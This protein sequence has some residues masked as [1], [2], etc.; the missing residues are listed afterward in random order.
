MQLPNEEIDISIECHRCGEPQKRGYN[1]CN[2]CGA[3]NINAFRRELKKDSN[4]SRNLTNLARYTFVIL[5]LIVVSIFTGDDL[6]SLIFWT[7]C[8]AIVDVIF[9]ILQPEVWSLFSIKNI[10]IKPLL[11]VSLFGILSGFLVSYSIEKLNLFLEL[12]TYNSIDIFKDLEYSLISAIVLTA[13]FPAIF[14]EMAF[15]GFIFN[16][17]TRLAG[18]KSAIWGSSFL[19][20]LVHFSLLSLYWIVP[21]GLF[22]AYF[23]N[24]YNTIIYGIV[25]H[26]I[27]NSTVV[28]IDH[29]ELF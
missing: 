22:L 19:F 13:V 23:R 1:F 27:H 12:E 6:Y 16:N 18:K 17:L 14:E 10:K 4:Y 21:F 29:Y 2:K 5:A 15:R 8:F 24:R 25:L 11:F 20:G 28:L 3:Q 26:F 9:G 7:T